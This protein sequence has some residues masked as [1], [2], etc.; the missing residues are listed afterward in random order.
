M[1]R[2]L[3]IY[4]ISNPKYS[5]FGMSMSRIR[6]SNGKLMT[7][8]SNKVSVMRLRCN[9]KGGLEEKSETMISKKTL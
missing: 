3:K 4:W 7:L 9:F 6:E 2:S 1:K 8:S 5:G